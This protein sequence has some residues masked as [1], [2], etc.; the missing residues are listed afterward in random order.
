MHKRI[1]LVILG[2]SFGLVLIRT[3]IVDKLL[4]FIF[5][6]VVPYSSYIVSPGSMLL[7][8]LIFLALLII[9]TVR[10]AAIAASPVRRD[11]ISRNRARRKVYAATG[12]KNTSV[13][14]RPKKRYLVV[15]EH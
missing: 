2:M 8:Y 13:P 1:G 5:A 7:F 15:T 6:G 3:D 12:A 11:V 10:K 4:A 14:T 9:Y